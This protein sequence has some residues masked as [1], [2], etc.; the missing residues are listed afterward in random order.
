MELP[1]VLPF[2]RLD[3]DHNDAFGCNPERAKQ[4]ESEK[5]AQNKTINVCFETHTAHKVC[6]KTA[7]KWN[8]EKSAVRRNLGA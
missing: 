8:F 5:Y 1:L 4:L 7:R 2:A 6:L 3:L